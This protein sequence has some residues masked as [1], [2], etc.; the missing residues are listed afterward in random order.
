MPDLWCGGKSTQLEECHFI[1]I[2]DVVQCDV[3][4]LV[5]ECVQFWIGIGR[6]QRQRVWGSRFQDFTR[7]SANDGFSN[8]GFL[9]G[10]PCTTAKCSPC[11]DKLCSNM[12]DKLTLER[13]P[14]IKTW[15]RQRN[16]YLIRGRLLRPPMNYEFRL[17]HLS[18]AFK[19]A[20]Q[21][22]K[23]PVSYDCRQIHLG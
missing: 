4:H 13:V 10:T 23:F 9:L 7:I 22:H 14:V 15:K 8:C 18:S 21:E 12:Y 1:T 11:L 6:K 20:W 5:V 16:I 17:R 3:V 2:E 19:N